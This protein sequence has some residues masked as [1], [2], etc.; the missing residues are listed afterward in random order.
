ML[1]RQWA[2]VDNILHTLATLVTGR[3]VIQM[4]P[5][6]EDRHHGAAAGRGVTAMNADATVAKNELRCF[7]QINLDIRLGVDNHRLDCLT[8]DTTAAIQDIHRE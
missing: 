2:G 8:G 6:H 4:I 7:F 1:V 3:V 5:L